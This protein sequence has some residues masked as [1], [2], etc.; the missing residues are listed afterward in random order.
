MYGTLAN[1][2]MQQEAE[3]KFQECTARNNTPKMFIT[4]A[5]LTQQM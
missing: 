4:K 3:K 5:F 1:D 2:E